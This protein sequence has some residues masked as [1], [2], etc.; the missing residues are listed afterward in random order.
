MFNALNKINDCLL[1]ICVV[2]YQYVGF[3][4]LQVS[5]VSTSVIW[6]TV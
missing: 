6:S 3:F 1:D 5:A 4:H 2:S